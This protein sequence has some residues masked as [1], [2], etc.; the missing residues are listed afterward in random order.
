MLDLGGTHSSRTITGK[1]GLGWALITQ[2]APSTSEVMKI[3][4]E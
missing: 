4:H 1:P 2:Y 3:V